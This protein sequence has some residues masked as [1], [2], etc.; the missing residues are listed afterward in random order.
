[1]S[2]HRQALQARARELEKAKKAFIEGAR[3]AREKAA[4]EQN[5]GLKVRSRVA[6]G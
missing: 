3:A 2:D 1:M 4:K 6:A 5:K